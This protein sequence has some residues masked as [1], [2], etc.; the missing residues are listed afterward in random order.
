MK[1][2]TF[3]HIVTIYLTLSLLFAQGNMTVFATETATDTGVV[4]YKNGTLAGEYSTVNQAFDQMVEVSSDYKILLK[5]SQTLTG[6]AN[7]PNVNSITIMPYNLQQGVEEGIIT[8]FIVIE[9]SITLHS[10]VCI[11][12]WLCF[13]PEQ[14]TGKVSYVDVDIQDFQL[15]FDKEVAGHTVSVGCKEDTWNTGVN[16]KG[17]LGSKI[18]LNETVQFYNSSIQVDTLKMN[19]N[20][21]GSKLSVYELALYDSKEKNSV[22]NVETYYGNGISIS[23]AEIE[24]DSFSEVTNP[25]DSTESVTQY[26]W[27]EG[28]SKAVIGNM[29]DSCNLK[30]DYLDMNTVENSSVSITGNMAPQAVMID[31]AVNHKIYNADASSAYTFENEGEYLLYAPNLEDG[32][33]TVVCTM[34]NDLNGEI[35]GSYSYYGQIEGENG[36]YNASAIPSIQFSDVF[37]MTETSIIDGLLYSNANANGDLQGVSWSIHELGTNGYV[38]HPEWTKTLGWDKTQ[39]GFGISGLK[40]TST[41]FLNGYFTYES[42]TVSVVIPIFTSPTVSAASFDKTQITLVKPTFTT[43]QLIKLN[44][45]ASETPE[46]IWTTSN[47]EVVSIAGNG[48]NASQKINGYGQAVITAYIGNRVLTCNILVTQYDVNKS[49]WHQDENGDWYYYKNGKVDT[50]RNGI[51][52]K[53]SEYWYVVKGKADFTVTTVAMY[54]NNWWYVKNGKINFSYTGLASNYSGWWYIKNGKLDFSYNGV[55]TNEEGTW[56]ILN[57]KIDTTKTGIHARGGVYYYFKKG[58]VDE[59]VNGFVK[60]SW[61]YWYFVNGKIDMDYVG[62]IENPYGLWYVQDGK[63]D[64]TKTGIYAEDGIYYYLRNGKFDESINGFVKNSWG[65]WYFVNGKIDFEYKGLIKNAYGLWYVQNGKIDDKYNDVATNE[66]GTWYV[67]NGKVDTTKTGIYARGGVYYY[68]RGGKFDESVNGFVKNSW[69]YWYFV[70]GKIDMDY[71]GLIENVYGLWYVKNGKI[72]STKN[73]ISVVDG[74]YYY[75]KNGQVNKG[76]NGFVRNT[77]G[78]WYFVNGKIDMDYVG[79]VK[80]TYGLWY[81]QNG[82]I[83]YLYND[84]ATNDDGIWYVLNGKVDT[85]KTGIYARGG[86]YYFFRSGKVDESVN[87]FVRN[88]WGCWYFVDGKIDMD[89]VGLVENAYGLWYVQEGKIDFAFNGTI[90]F[91]GKTYTVVNGFATLIE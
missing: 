50:S 76:V 35:D 71:V 10:D 89:Y 49:G 29:Y 27:L 22:K 72:D 46:V 33:V 12:D 44:Y 73:G 87:G 1:K 58:K 37:F 77:W 79:L 14:Q 23:N 13:R 42:G 20:K 41:Y 88:T 40:S 4:L 3:K 31:M 16:I 52:P 11:S 24:I 84:V 85:T 53:G 91:E 57:G 45:T 63:I 28:A 51:I 75:F 70:N 26:L 62:L 59:S 48:V 8:D 19:G 6:Y 7:W 21:A 56:Y 54:N 68:F 2:L 74:T 34:F 55:A 81:V 18:V 32:K 39:L 80:N 64:T 15:T 66:E 65:Y 67:L 78:C 86:V 25:I 82:K 36:Y 38:D 5:N 69:G 83:D 60:N 30:I 17:D 43:S 61:G 9:D 90:E 47:P